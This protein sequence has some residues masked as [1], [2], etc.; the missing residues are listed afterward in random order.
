MK[1][2]AAQAYASAKSWRLLAQHT[3]EDDFIHRRALSMASLCMQQHSELMAFAQHMETVLTAPA[4][5][6]PTN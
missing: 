2:L 1:D 4:P 6:T 5:P 3:A